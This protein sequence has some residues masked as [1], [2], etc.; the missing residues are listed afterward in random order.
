LWYFFTLFAL[1]LVALH[2][3][4]GL[5]RENTFQDGAYRGAFS[6]FI[7]QRDIFHADGAGIAVVCICIS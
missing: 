1:Y 7:K 2:N 3:Y 6:G 4:G 5:Y